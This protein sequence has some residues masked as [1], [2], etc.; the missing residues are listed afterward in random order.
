MYSPASPFMPIGTAS[1]IAAATT[2]PAGAQIA[3]DPT[4]EVLGT[5]QYRLHNAGNTTVYYATGANATLAQ[6][7]AIVPTNTTVGG[8][9]PLPAGAIEVITMKVGQYWS[10][11]T[12]GSNCSFFVSPGLGV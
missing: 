6:T 2:A 9:H 7:A 8:G 12:V 1:L 11:I 4:T 3:G 5:R 10:G